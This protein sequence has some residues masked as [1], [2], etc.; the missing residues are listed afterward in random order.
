MPGTHVAPPRRTA[1]TVLTAEIALALVAATVPVAVLASAAA[2]AAAPRAAW[3][4]NRL[5][6]SAANFD[7][8][9]G[10]W[11]ASTGRVSRITTPVQSGTG[12]LSATNT[13]TSAATVIAKSGSSAS[14]WTPAAAGSRWRGCASSRAAKTGRPVTVTIAFLDSTGHL[15]DQAQGQ[16]TS[17][18]SS[19]WTKLAAAVAIAPPKSAYAELLVSFH[20]AA[21]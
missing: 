5:T 3:S 7:S 6:G 2:P 13:G 16:S 19:R 10:G 15:L 18:A 17:D 21:A 14:T 8:S 1:R 12:A 11:A 4:A 20:S 9:T